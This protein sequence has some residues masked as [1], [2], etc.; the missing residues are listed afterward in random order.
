MGEQEEGVACLPV[1]NKAYIDAM[2][3]RRAQ[4]A[5]S[6]KSLLPLKKIINGS[7]LFTKGHINI[8]PSDPINSLHRNLC[9]E[10]RSKGC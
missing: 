3:H 9:Q 10:Q 5:E 4:K 6:E 1:V 8:F 2:G 7:F